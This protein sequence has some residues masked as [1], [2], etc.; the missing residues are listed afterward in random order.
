LLL[1]PVK[2]GLFNISTETPVIPDLED[3]EKEDLT[4]QVAAPPAIKAN[5]ITTLRELDQ[6]LTLDSTDDVRF[7]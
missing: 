3:V 2:D 6:G 1:I 7:E 5:R 4:T